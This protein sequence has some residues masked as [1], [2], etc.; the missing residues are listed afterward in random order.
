[1]PAFIDFN[2]EQSD[3]AKEFRFTETTGAYDGNDNTGGWGTP[4]EA[5]PANPTSVTLTVTPPDGTAVVLDLSANYP[6]VDRTIEEVID[7]A[8]LGSTSGAQ[9]EDGAWTFLY[10]VNTGVNTYTNTQTILVSGQA[11]CC[12]YG[13]LCDATACNCDGAS[14]SRALEAY[15]Y[16]RMLIA[17]A[18]CGNQTKF[19]ETLEIVEAYCEDSCS[20]CD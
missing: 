9:L 2:I 19:E 8:D 1:M 7:S 16:Y 18:L 5:L 17:C 15:T 10:T 3:N 6:T 4:N 20:C 11:R 12:V 14:L 13:M